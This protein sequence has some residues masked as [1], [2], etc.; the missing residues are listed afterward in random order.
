MIADSVQNNVPLS[1]KLLGQKMGTNFLPSNV[2][3]NLEEKDG[4]MRVRRSVSA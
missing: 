3:K 4:Q 2:V 1:Q